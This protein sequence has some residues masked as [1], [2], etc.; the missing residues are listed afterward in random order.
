MI[1]EIRIAVAFAA[2]FCALFQTPAQAQEMIVFES[3]YLH[4]NDT[5][6]VFSPGLKGLERNI[7]TL[8]LLHGYSGCYS[9]WSRHTDLQAVSDK[10]GFRIICPDGFYKGW[11]L[12]NANPQE[13]QW[14]SFFWEECWPTLDFRYGLA[15]EKTF[16]D[17]LSMGGHGAMNIFLDHPEKFRGGGSMSGVLALHHTGGSK[18]IIPQ[19]L[20][21]ES[22]Y[23][24]VCAA[25]SAINRLPRIREICGEEGAA[26]KIIIISCGTEDSFMKASKEFEQRCTEL[27]LRHVAFYS[28]GRHNWPY[29]VWLLPYHLQL[30]ADYL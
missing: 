10:S 21:V 17:G 5:V 24:P 3:E 1:K 18:D 22:I 23:D 6:L 13:M 25:Q 9:D 4:C 7:P 30:F 2:A 14:R 16:V 27:G 15:P 8:F 12:N 11:Y 20:G 19:I 29:W 28:P 26:G